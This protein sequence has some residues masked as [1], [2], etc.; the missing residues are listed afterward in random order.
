MPK[1]IFINSTSVSQTELIKQGFRL[2]AEEADQRAGNLRD[3]LW[4]YPERTAPTADQLINPDGSTW[5][6]DHRLL[7][8]SS[9]LVPKEHDKDGPFPHA[10]LFASAFYFIE[11]EKF[12]E[13]GLTDLAWRDLTQAYY[14]LGMASSDLTAHESASNAAKIKHADDS[15]QIRAVVCAIAADLATEEPRITLV[16]ARKKVINAIEESPAHMTILQYFDNINR[17]REVNRDPEKTIF[18]RF[19]D[20][21]KKWSEP[22]GKKPDICLAFDPFRRRPRGTTSG[23][24]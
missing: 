2:W 3:K 12:A 16:S 23:S 11:S 21:L 4:R 20:R 17:D 8:V 5:A 13:A 10:G 18:D 7:I 22:S 14:Y 1:S 15:A 6:D 9:S 24:N 19:S